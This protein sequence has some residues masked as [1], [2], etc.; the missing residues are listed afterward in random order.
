MFVF[1]SAV[2]RENIIGEITLQVDIDKP[3]LTMGAVLLYL[4][5][6]ETLFLTW[7][8]A[9]LGSLILKMNFQVFTGLR[10]TANCVG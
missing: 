2:L 8:C 3:L 7:F 6:N 4:F 5:Y 1:H 10:H 9:G